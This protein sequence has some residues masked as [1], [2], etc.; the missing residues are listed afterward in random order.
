MRSFD[1]TTLTLALSLVGGAV[2]AGGSGLNTVVVVNQ[3]SPD[4]LQLGNDYC[5][6]RGVPP[7]NV[8]RLTNWTGDRVQ[9]SS[10]QFET[11]LRQPLLGLLATRGLTNQVE[12]VL[13]SMDIP[14]RV[15][16]SGS[17][18]ST[19]SALFYGF[20]PDTAPP[21]GLPASC[22][23]P[24]SSANSYAY[25][26]LPFAQAR[27]ANATTN[28]FLAFM[29]TADNL[30]QAQTILARGVASDSTFPTQTV[31]LAR[32]GD[33][34]R[35]V[36]YV[37]FDEALFSTRVQ[38]DYSMVK[39]DTSSTAFTNLLGLQTGLATLSLLTNAF[40]PGA[41]GDSLTSYA[42]ALFENSGQ[43][44]LLAF[45]NAGTAGSYGAVVEPCNYTEKF[46]N[47][48]DYFYQARGFSLAEAYYQSLENPYQGLLVGEPLS[49]PFARRGSAQWTAPSDGSVL[50]GP[51]TLRIE[52]LAANTNLPLSQVD[53]FLDGQ[54]LQTV[55][56]LPPA[57]GNDLAVT[58]NGFTVHHTVTTNATLA[59]VALSLAAALNAETNST[60]VLAY[61]VGDRLELQSLSPAPP[62]SQFSISATTAAGTAPALTTFLT[63]S[64]TN[65]LDGTATGYRY[66][67]IDNATNTGDWI[68]LQFFKTNGTQ[69]TVSV[70]NTTYSTN[71]SPFVQSL[72]N[73]IN[74]TAA[75][76]SADG[77]LASDFAAAS[78]IPAAEFYLYARNAGWPA[79]RIQ[80][81]ASASVG[82]LVQPS[83]TN[84][85]ESNL[86][87]LR[88]RNNLY[89]SAG[90]SHLPLNLTLD[91]T[92]LAD[93]FHEL[94]AV[95]YEGTSVRTQT[96]VSRSVQIQNTPL[97]AALATLVGGSNTALEA[98][99]QFTITAYTN[100]LAHVELFTTGG[101]V[102]AATNPAAA[103]FALAAT[104][105]G[106]GL[107]PFYAVVTDR[108]GKTYR[109]QTQWLRIVN[110]E[111]PFNL[112][113]SGI[114]LTLSWPALAGRQY[115]IRST[116][117]LANTFQPVASVLAS[118]CVGLWPLPA[119]GAANAWFRVRSAP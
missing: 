57:A 97:T 46:P 66:F 81:T 80:V 34:A 15:Y 13:L 35:S 109:T 10:A 42:G 27:P 37:E 63:A 99:L 20:K 62:G 77:V 69:V 32:T 51:A 12:Q 6:L 21:A 67:R 79:A 85:L 71:Y 1:L 96:R 38:G 30:L 93:G 95:A 23:L 111:T 75:L 100:N 83:G 19:T 60:H 55:T 92:P 40:V 61:P 56:N 89:V 113:L 117:N 9:W 22:S 18:N 53:L 44:P 82:V 47:P 49:A 54:F 102:G 58:L 114:P 33:A 7:Q 112:T 41:I 4:S 24:P 31:Y 88:A 5:E 91:T 50:T 105:L 64:R 16:D 29:L 26:E 108:L 36:R 118:N 104:S 14:Y 74:A 43:T 94:T 39:I 76:Q 72:V 52:F 101:S 2:W 48:L 119:S 103:T 59:S 68:A 116:T 90:A 28:A 11:S 78:R 17:Q 45:L 8:L 107:H 70:T 115:E 98:T 73:A 25:S 84:Y 3:N 110:T 65:F 106:L 86:G 87:V